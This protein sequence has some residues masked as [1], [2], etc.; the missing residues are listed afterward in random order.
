V[1]HFDFWLP[2]PP[3]LNNAYENFR[4]RNKK[5]G[6]MVTRRRKS[7]EYALWQTNAKALI[8]HLVKPERRIAGPV[9]VAIALPE[10]MRGDVDNRIKPILDALV[11]SGRIDDDR[12]VIEVSAGKR[13][14]GPDRAFVSVNAKWPE[15]A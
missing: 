5:T 14:P 12:N 8:A 9:C 15:A 6:R 2:M 1:S 4:A 10:K 7:D 13:L 3:S 11:A